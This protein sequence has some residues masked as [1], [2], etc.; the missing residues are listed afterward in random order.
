MADFKSQTSN[1]SFSSVLTALSIIAISLLLS[2]CSG[3]SEAREGAPVPV[4]P[5]PEVAQGSRA[6]GSVYELAKQIGT[7]TDK[8][9]SEVSG[10]TA[11]R[12]HPGI[13][14]VHNDSGDEA[15]IYALDQNG[16][17][18]ATFSVP[19]AKN[20]DWE[21]IG[22]G[23]GRDGHPALYIAD[24][25]DNGR[26]RDELVVYRVPEPAVNKNETT[27]S[28]ETAEAFP[29]IYPDGKHDAE[30]IF[31]DQ[32]SGRI[33]LVTKIRNGGGGVYRF[34][35]PLTPGTRVTLERVKGGTVSEIE[36]LPLVT[37]AATSPDNTR[38]V[39]RTYFT[40]IELQR[41]KGGVFE[42]IFNAA[43]TVVSIPL[44]RQGEAIAYTADGKAIVTTSEKV[45]AP[46]YQMTRQ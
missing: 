38:V 41:T 8:K 5:W 9:L 32:Q 36:K 46:I 42:T 11:G 18:I 17:L 14:W 31:I 6:G 21:D 2:A 20:V 27:G 33:Y 34:P 35:L 3:H 44:E 40:A 39:I 15:R 4:R 26:L 1:L 43:P 13:W 24:T 25:G 10:I 29:F 23:P 19:G 12:R 45:P 22:S 16:R 28:T 7:I 30:A 37:G